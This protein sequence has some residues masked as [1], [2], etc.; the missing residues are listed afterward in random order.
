MQFLRDVRQ[1]RVHEDLWR[2][3][4]SE[5]E[6]VRPDYTFGLANERV[7]EPDIDSK[8]VAVRLP[9]QE[10]PG[11]KALPGELHSLAFDYRPMRIADNFETQEVTEI[12]PSS[13]S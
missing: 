4:S 3:D 9:G 1:H 5:L 12:Q 13:S 2:G 11:G 7:R 10:T 8:R 6:E